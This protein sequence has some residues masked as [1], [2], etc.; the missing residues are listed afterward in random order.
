MLTDSAAFGYEN[1]TP[2]QHN[3]SPDNWLLDDVSRG[4]IFFASPTQQYRSRCCSGALTAFEPIVTNAIS[5]EY[6][7]SIPPSP[8]YSPLKNEPF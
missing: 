2:A 4:D 1:N 6:L 5:W 3:A 8:R 7:W